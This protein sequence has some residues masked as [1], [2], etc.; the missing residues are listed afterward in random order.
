MI[1]LVLAAGMP[2]KAQQAPPLLPSCVPAPSPETDRWPVAATDTLG[3]V[4]AGQPFTFSSVF[5]LGND[6]GRTALTVVGV[7][8]RSS[9][10]G[11]IVDGGGGM[12]TYRSDVLFAGTDIFTYEISD[13]DGQTTIGLVKIDV[14]AA[15][16][17]TT[18]PTVSITSPTGTV[19]GVA[20]IVAT[21]ADNVGVVGVRFFDGAAAIGAAVPGP[22]FSTTWN[23]VLVA[24]GSHD[25]TAVARD[26]AGNSTTS[27]I[28]TVNVANTTVVPNVVGLTG[29]AAQSAIA[30]ANLTLG[31]VTSANSATVPAGQVISQSPAA[32]G[33][34]ARNSA[35]SY[36]LSLGAPVVGVPTVQVNV[37]ADGTGPRT[38]SPFSTTSPGEVLIALAASDGPTAGTNNQTLTISGGGLSWTRVRRVAVQRGVAEI[39]TATASTVLTNVTVTSTQ[40]V[41]SVNGLAVNQSLTVLAF[42]G[43]AG[44]GASNVASGAT[45]APR[46]SLVTQS[47]GSVVY[48]V[49]IDFDRAVAR[50]VPAGQTKVH[51]FLAPSGDTMWM[52]SLNGTTGA[53]GSTATLNDTAPTTDQWNFAGVEI[54]SGT[55]PASVTVPSVV[56]MVQA[57]AQSAITGAGLTVGTITTSSSPTVAAGSVISQSPAGASSALAGSAV[58][59]VVST[60]APPPVPTAQVT[61]F[62]DGA[63]AQTTPAFSTTAPGEVLVAFA[64]S[65]GPTSGTNNQFLTVSGAGLTWTRVARAATQRGVSEIWAATAPT[66]LSNVTVTST[67]SVTVVLSAP[68]NQSLTV[69][70]FTNASGV[71]ASNVGG[72]A[73]GA[74]TISVVAQAADSAV[75]AVGNDFDQA[76]ARTIPAGQTKVHEFLAPSGDT[77]WVQ[78]LSGTTASAGATV[79]LRA[80]AP[81]GDQWNFAIVE[82]KR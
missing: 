47:A 37:S 32:G 66:V 41:T 13:A 77:F 78:A 43:A 17:D 15:P 49:G 9:H 76:I 28:V 54:M 19:S 12:F 34:V 3:S 27:A 56:G 61:V 7:G 46:V 62:K 11:T 68:V 14:T 55:P 40:S 18:A 20:T 73:S 16:A 64:T 35:V 25:L 30:G 50:T 4:V 8:P 31:T 2:M 63:G 58:S 65:D 81:T 44:V 1:L 5:L 57:A 80:T 59:L 82:I 75:Y 39:W 74:P 60:G 22:T 23:T 52:Q 10:G 24:D 70:A 71:G 51:E 48:G 45:G 6:T 72:A 69:V 36:V 33:T 42:T 53:A 67:Q 26:A 79:T 29:A 38:T 21:A